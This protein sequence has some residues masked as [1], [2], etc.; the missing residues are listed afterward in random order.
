MR[1]SGDVA[2]ELGACA[3]DIQSDVQ[4]EVRYSELNTYRA[5]RLIFSGFFLDHSEAL[6][7]VGLA[8]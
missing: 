1:G 6:K 8:E 2:G 7:A 5:G 4:G 3:L